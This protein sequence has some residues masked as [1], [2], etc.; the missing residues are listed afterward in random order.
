LLNKYFVDEFYDATVIEP[1]KK[2]SE[3]ILWKF[4]DVKIIDGFVN[5]VAAVVA[6]LSEWFKKFQVGVTQVYAVVM[7]AGIAI[8]LFWI[9]ASF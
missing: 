6:R 5:G 4:T 8:V 1:I 7:L 9:I 2:G 3:S